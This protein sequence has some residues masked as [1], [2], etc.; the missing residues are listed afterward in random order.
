[1]GRAV[2]SARQGQLREGSNRAGR[3]G[4]RPHK[5]A[6]QRQTRGP[7]AGLRSSCAV[8]TLGGGADGGCEARHEGAGRAAQAGTAGEGRWGAQQGCWEGSSPSS[9]SAAGSGRDTAAELAVGMGA[10]RCGR[11]AAASRSAGGP[12]LNSFPQQSRTS[13]LKTILHRAHVYIRLAVKEFSHFLFYG[14]YFVYLALD[15]SGY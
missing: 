7:E 12:E 1:M 3:H 13:L 6:V 5:S 8:G 14:C 2:A 4:L 11:G 10:R 15:Q 9:S